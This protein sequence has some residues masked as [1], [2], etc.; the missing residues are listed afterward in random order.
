MGDSTAGPLHLGF[1][2]TEKQPM[3]TEG[4][5]SRS[6]EAIV[7]GRAK[8]RPHSPCCD[9]DSPKSSAMEAGYKWLV[10]DS[11]SEEDDC[12]NQGK[13]SKSPIC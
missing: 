6:A 8:K 3:E 7:A 13:N 1:V 11:G 12:G 10:S 5:E 2:G 4:G 9:E